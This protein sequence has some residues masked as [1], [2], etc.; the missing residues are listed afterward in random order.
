MSVLPTPDGKWYVT[1]YFRYLSD[2]WV[3][4]GVK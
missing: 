4:D 3:V 2:L 1:G